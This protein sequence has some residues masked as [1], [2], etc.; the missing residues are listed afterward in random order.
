MPLPIRLKGWICLYRATLFYCIFGYLCG[1]VLFALAAGHLFGKDVLKDSKDQNP[2]TANAFMHGGFFCGFLTLAGDLFKG[3]FPVWLCLMRVDGVRGSL[4]FPLVL[5]APVIGHIF[6]L[7]RRFRGGKGIATS[8]GALAALLPD[9]RPLL[10]LAFFFLFFSLVLRISP[11]YYRTIAT[12]L[13]TTVTLFV[14][15]EGI[16][17]QIGFGLICV[18][19]LF[20][21]LSSREERKSIRVNLLW[22]H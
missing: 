16:Y 6:P 2:G 14:L 21:L 12:Y 5:A 8:F 9:L 15:R 18:A 13:A 19:V 3:F 11:H 1:S 22:K 17:V 20:R 4:L 7:F 10:S